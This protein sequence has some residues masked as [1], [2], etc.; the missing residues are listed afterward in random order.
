MYDNYNYPLG[1]DTPDAP[2]NEPVIPERDFEVDVECVI[3]KEGVLITTNKYAPEYDE[4]DGRTYAN[5]EDTDWE[6][7]YDESHHT[8]IELLGELEQYIIQDLERYKGNKTK[9]RQLNAMLE[10]CKGWYF[11]DKTFTE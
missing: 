9:E 4:E 6:K 11:V 10:D 2:W 8:I 7:E 5:T 1:A 3:K